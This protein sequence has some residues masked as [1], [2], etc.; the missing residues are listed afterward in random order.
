[1]HYISNI[2]NDLLSYNTISYKRL[3]T[4]KGY[5]LK[6]NVRCHLKVYR[7]LRRDDDTIDNKK[8]IKKGTEVDILKVREDN[9]SY[10]QYLVVDK[11]KKIKGWTPAKNVACNVSNSKIKIF[12]LRR[13]PTLEKIF[14]KG[15]RLK[16]D[17]EVNILSVKD[18]LYEVS[19]KNSSLSS[20]DPT[21]KVTKIASKK[22]LKETLKK[23]PNKPKKTPTDTKKQKQ[24]CPIKRQ[25]IDPKT[26]IG[27]P[28][29]VNSTIYPVYGSVLNI[30]KLCDCI[31][32]D[33]AGSAFQNGSTTY[34]GGGFSGQVYEMFDINGV[35]MVNQEHKFG[36]DKPAT[37]V[38]WNSG[39]DGIEAIIHAI[40][41]SWG[42][43]KADATF[44]NILETTVQNIA[45][46]MRQKTKKTDIALP[47]LSTGIFGPLYLDYNE[48]MGKYIQFIENYLSGYTVYLSLF[49]KK[50]QDAFDQYSAGKKVT[51][52]ASKKATPLEKLVEF[53]KSEIRKNWSGPTHFI[54]YNGDVVHYDDKLTNFISKHII[55]DSL[56]R[57]VTRDLIQF[58]MKHDAM[59]HWRMKFKT[60]DDVITHFS[61]ENILPIM[62]SDDGM[63]MI[64]EFFSKHK[65]KHKLKTLK[66][67]KKSVNKDFSVNKQPEKK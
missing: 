11:K 42:G 33:A 12:K 61:Q 3:S 46:E 51:P 34:G 60:V 24:V 27:E 5:M 1:M 7:L 43:R 4:V 18:E 21:I 54:H 20:K 65:P 67:G 6:K 22:E 10:L 35:K 63:M 14:M 55:L 8:G 32:V 57:K 50:E 47:L 64:S 45:K 31:L 53:I 39:V 29:K 25:T 62:W 59:E 52:T 16:N 41:P 23:T 9:N 17:D 66:K 48:F 15:V 13:K 36:T 28:V 49:S 40:G 26:V 37:W 19:P 58:I 2:V 30:Q 38:G 44:Y 56:D